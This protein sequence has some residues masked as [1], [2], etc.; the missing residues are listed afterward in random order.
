MEMVK[1]EIS[2]SLCQ[3]FFNIW[4]PIAVCNRCP[5]YFR[6]NNAIIVNSKSIIAINKSIIA[7]KKS[8]IAINKSI[9]SID[10]SIHDIYYRYAAAEPHAVASLL[11]GI[12]AQE[13]RVGG[14]IR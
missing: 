12:A 3:P 10:K 11:G 7:I 9:I 2:W 1:R 6:I 14:G 4:E 5:K 13:V 8:I